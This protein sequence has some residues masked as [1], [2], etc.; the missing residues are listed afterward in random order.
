M[1]KMKKNPLEIQRPD[2]TVKVNFVPFGYEAQFYDEKGESLGF[3]CRDFADSYPINKI[4]DVVIIEMMLALQ[5]ADKDYKK[6]HPK[7]KVKK[8]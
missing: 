1:A 5:E 7:K 4:R 2:L 3:V 8:K 6:L